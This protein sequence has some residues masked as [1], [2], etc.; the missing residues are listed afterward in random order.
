MGR[1]RQISRGRAAERSLSVHLPPFERLVDAHAR[2]LHRFLVGLVGPPRR[3]IASRRPTCP[4][5]APTQPPPSQNL[6]AWLYTIA[7]R[8]ATDVVRRRA[9]RPTRDLDGIDPVRRRRGTRPTTASGARSPL[10]AKQ[11]VAMTPVRA[12]PRIRRDRGADGHQRGGGAPERERR[13][14]TA[15]ARGDG[16]DRRARAPP[17]GAAPPPAPGPGGLRDELA[18][19]AADAGCSISP[20][21]RLTHRS[22]R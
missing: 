17:R 10:P 15:A 19:R 16:D 18:R 7:Q 1:Q 5:S 4:R 11:R 12:R 20:T 6:R 2:E 13:P 8:K 3:R 22:A 9:R 14:A 21:A